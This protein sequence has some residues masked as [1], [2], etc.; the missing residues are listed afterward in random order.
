[1]PTQAADPDLTILLKGG[2]GFEQMPSL[3]MRAP[4]D[5]AVIRLLAAFSD[6]LRKQPEAVAFP[7][8]M[9]FSFFI[10]PAQLKRFEESY[11]DLRES[12]L[13]RGVTFH[14]APSN[15]P[16]MFAYTLVIGLLSGN[17]CIVR[18]SEKE[19]AQVRIVCEVLRAILEQPEHQRLADYIAVVRYGHDLRLNSFFSSLCDVRIIWGGDR[20][21]SEIRR[22]PLPPKSY[23]MLFPDRY[24]ALII[25]ADFYLAASDK[26]RVADGFYNDTY[27]FD[28]GACSSPRLLY[29]VGDVETVRAAQEQ[30]WDQVQES[31]ERRNYRN[32]PVTTVSKYVTLCRAAIDTG[33]VEHVAMPDNRIVRI[34]LSTLDLELPEYD[35]IGGVF[36]EFIHSDLELVG[37]FISRKLQTLA[38]LGFDNA[39][40]RSL[41]LRQG[42]GGVDRIVP[43][44][45]AGSFS[46]IWDG[47]DVIRHM[48][49]LITIQ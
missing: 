6:A 17:A 29:W 48:S 41:L 7:D 45:E 4:F 10:R 2:L 3:P 18:V 25:R 12:S 31:L 39:E 8:I 24:S 46:L 1:M 9:A 49:R 33:S 36:F 19:F 34:D 27:L 43:V 13:G 30:F 20:A 22:A 32:E 11:A 14:I 44:G 23:E 35:C 5:P 38:Y 28:Q 15:V 26:V 16:I 42:V 40:L 37:K 47:Y 21:I